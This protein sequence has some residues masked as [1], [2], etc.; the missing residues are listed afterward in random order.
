[1]EPIPARDVNEVRFDDTVDVVVVGLGV[2]GACATVAARRGGSGRPGRRAGHGV[3]RNLGQLRRPDLPRRWHGPPDR[4]RLRGLG[5]EHG[6]LP[7]LLPRTRSG[8]RT[9]RLPTAR[10]RRSTS[11][12]WSPSASLSG[13]RSATNRTGSQPTTR[14]SSSAGERTRTPL[15]RSRSP[16]H[17]GTSHASSTRPEG[18]SWNDSVPRCRRSG[19]RVMT[20]ARAQALIVDGEAIVGVE[21]QT[22][23]GTR[24]VRA[25]GGVV[26]A[27]GGFIHNEAMV[28]EY[29]PLAHVPDAAWRIGTPNDDGR[30]IRLGVGAGAAT[31]PAPRLR[32]RAAPRAAAPPR[33]GHPRRPRRQAVHQRGHLYRAHRAACAARP[34]RR[35]LHDHRRRDPRAEPSWA[36]A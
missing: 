34:R 15:T 9:P 1:M 25:R 28:A 7:A 6:R 3:G 12:G 35:H 24:A 2:A 5:R 8:R 11:T 14:G 30:G 29:C 18:S 4:L 26:L 36:C 17:V 10:V 21:V 23:D 33:P 22:D 16:C 13:P 27:M 19:A 31:T 20:D 32:M